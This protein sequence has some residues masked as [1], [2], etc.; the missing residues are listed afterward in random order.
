MACGEMF[1]GPP[2]TIFNLNSTVFSDASRII[3][4]MFDT[5]QK[6]TRTE[7]GDLR[8]HFAVLLCLLA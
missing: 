8:S 5:Y 2:R 4:K 1:S 6:K 3:R 7:Q